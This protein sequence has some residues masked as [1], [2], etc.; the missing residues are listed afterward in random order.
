MANLKNAK[1]P[2]ATALSHLATPDH[3]KSQ[4]AIPKLSIDLAEAKHLNPYVEH[5][6]KRLRAL[7]KRMVLLIQLL[8]F[9]Y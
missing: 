4:D 2:R 7:R 3:K 1:K 6:A 8:L 5:V 9:H